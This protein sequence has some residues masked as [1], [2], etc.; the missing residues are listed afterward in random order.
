M[1]AAW[2]GARRGPR[3]STTVRVFF[4]FD[5]RRV[6]VLLIG[7]DKAGRTK[8]FYTQMIAKADRIYDAHLRDLLED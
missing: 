6:A 2:H 1:A 3:S 7:G 4:A 5:P 8:R